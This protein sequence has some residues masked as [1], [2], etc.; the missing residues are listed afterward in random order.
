MQAPDVPSVVAIEKRSFPTP[1]SANIFLKELEQN[2]LAR[3]DVL[4]RR[5][6]DQ[7][8]LLLGYAGYWLVAG[9]MHIIVIA[10]DPDQRR[11]GYGEILLLNML[12]SG[13]EI[14]SR[15]ITLEVRESNSVAQ[16]LYLKYGFEIFSLR[17]KYYRDTGED[18]ILMN[19][20][21]PPEPE[22]IDFLRRR[23]AQLYERLAG[24]AF[25]AARV[26]ESR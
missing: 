20:Q 1:R 9:E 2:S 18:A 16:T 8:Q 25:P 19:I 5:G 13:I 12:L 3:Y 7:Q 17:R 10:V 24:P 14:E 26:Q 4:L 21:L 22:H 15:L 23:A 6:P 11:H